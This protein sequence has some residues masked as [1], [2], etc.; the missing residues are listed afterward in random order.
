MGLGS[1]QSSVGEVLGDD[2]ARSQKEG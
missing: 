2:G 1:T